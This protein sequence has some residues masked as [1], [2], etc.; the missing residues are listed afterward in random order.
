MANDHLRPISRPVAR[1]IYSQ[2][3]EIFW[4]RRLNIEDS[5]TG[6]N[7]TD[8]AYPNLQ[9]KELD[10]RQLH[11]CSDEWVNRGDWLEAV[12]RLKEQGKVKFF[13]VPEDKLFPA[14]ER[15]HVGDISCLLGALR[16]GRA[17]RCLGAPHPVRKSQP[18]LRRRSLK[19]RTRKRRGANS[20]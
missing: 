3:R 12:Q 11:I 17:E 13:G 15:H 2:V 1:A 4:R 19:E 5:N 14:C 16:A 9:L 8:G 18:K 10:V 7:A 20:R 6:S